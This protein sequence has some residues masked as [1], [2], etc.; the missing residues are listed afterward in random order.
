M[1]A[2]KNEG[3]FVNFCYKILTFWEFLF[4]ALAHTTGIAMDA[5]PDLA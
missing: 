2:K 4:T 1:D 5:L 3:R